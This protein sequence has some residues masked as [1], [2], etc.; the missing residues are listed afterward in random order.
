[1]QLHEEMFNKFFQQNDFP[2]PFDPEGFGKFIQDQI[3]NAMPDNEEAKD[4]SNQGFSPFGN[5]SAGR[6]G[7]YD[8]NPSRSGL[9]IPQQGQNIAQP[10]VQRKGT[11]SGL[12][13]STGTNP[14]ETTNQELNY[15]A[16][17]THEDI[18]IRVQVPE[19]EA[20]QPVR[21]LQNSHQVSFYNEDHNRPLLQIQLPKPVEPKQTKMGFRQGVLEVKLT[22]KVQEPMTEINLSDLFNKNQEQSSNTKSLLE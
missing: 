12:G 14:P 17:E 2:N 13:R 18:I 19:D 9:P 20:N 7:T 3:K 21:F 10:P 6:Q 15:N 16:F 5:P 22:K 1:M 4:Q 8:F 11:S